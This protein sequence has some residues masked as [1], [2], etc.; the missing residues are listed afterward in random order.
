[1]RKRFAM[2]LAAGALMVAMVPGAASADI[3]VPD[4]L[5]PPPETTGFVLSFVGE[6]DLVA[7]RNG[8]GFVCMWF[9]VADGLDLFI[10]NN[11]PL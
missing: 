3:I 11:R 9:G 4:G 6:S 7:D 8:D 10:D 5:C 2:A 1:M